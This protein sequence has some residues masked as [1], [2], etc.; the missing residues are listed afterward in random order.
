MESIERPV[1]PRT[2]SP[3]ASPRLLPL[4]SLVRPRSARPFYSDI[5]IIDFEAGRTDVFPPALKRI[6]L[7]THFHV[8]LF[9]KVAISDVR[10][11]KQ[12]K[13]YFLVGGEV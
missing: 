1:S 13:N 5:D 3:R 11:V 2:A 4:R 9:A 12:I 6:C 10:N 8:N 7:R